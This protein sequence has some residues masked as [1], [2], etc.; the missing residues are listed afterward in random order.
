MHTLDHLVIFLRTHVLKVVRYVSKCC[1]MQM[2][3]AKKMLPFHIFGAY[4]EERGAEL[5]NYDPP[6]A[7]DL[8]FFC[9]ASGVGGFWKSLCVCGGS[10]SVCCVTSITRRGGR[11]KCCHVLWGLLCPPGEPGPSISWWRKCF[12]RIGLHRGRRVD[13]DDTLAQLCDGVAKQSGWRQ[14]RLPFFAPCT[15]KIKIAQIFFNC[16]RASFVIWAKKSCIQELL[17]KRIESRR[18]FYNSF[19]TQLTFDLWRVIHTW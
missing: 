2:P 13:T 10:S 15:C 17:S 9:R 5:R 12:E 18:D 14:K 4:A 7:Q 19:W 16:R 1:Q 3:K 8:N 6:D 11:L